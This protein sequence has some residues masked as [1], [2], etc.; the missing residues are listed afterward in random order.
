MKKLGKNL[1]VVKE[2][3]EAYDC[4]HSCGSC[5]C[6]CSCGGNSTA[7]Y[8]STSGSRSNSYYRVGYWA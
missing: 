4:W 2:S 7:M 6:S 8:Y 3:V 1:N 5:D